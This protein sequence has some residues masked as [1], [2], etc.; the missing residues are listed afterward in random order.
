MLC[1]LAKSHPLYLHPARIHILRGTGEPLPV[2]AK[3]T[4]DVIKEKKLVKICKEL[5]S[6]QLPLEKYANLQ[7]TLGLRAQP[8]SYW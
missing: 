3:T 7:M 1:N 2:S 5:T 8:T 6:N 4:N